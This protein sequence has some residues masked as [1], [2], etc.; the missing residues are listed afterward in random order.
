[1]NFLLALLDFLFNLLEQDLIEPANLILQSLLKVSNPHDNRSEIEGVF[2]EKFIDL[3]SLPLVILEHIAVLLNS[4]RVALLLALEI[5]HVLL[6]DVRVL[7][8]RLEQRL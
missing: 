8:A 1:M 7:I 4:D 3:V 5:L 2:K 6:Q